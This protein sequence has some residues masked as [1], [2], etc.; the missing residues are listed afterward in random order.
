MKHLRDVVLFLAGVLAFGVL[1]FLLVP[2]GPGSPRPGDGFVL[3]VLVAMLAPAWWKPARGLAAGFFGALTIATLFGDAFFARQWWS[4]VRAAASALARPAMTAYRERREQRSWLARWERVE[5]DHGEAAFRARL[6][7]TACL[8]KW[9][10]VRIDGTV[11]T[12]AELT[13]LDDCGD[14]RRDARDLEVAWP[15][16]FHQESDK[17]WRWSLAAAD[18]PSLRPGPGYVIRLEPEPLLG[19]AGPFLELD[20]RDVMRIRD[21]AAAPSRIYSTP[22]PLMLRLHD[23]FTLGAA[24][25]PDTAIGWRFLPEQR[26][27]RR[28][29]RELYL[30]ESNSVPPD[31]DLEF[32]ASERIANPG[33]QLWTD[34]RWMTYKLVGPRRF[35]LRGSQHFRRYLVS[36]DRTVHVTTENRPATTADPPPLPCEVDVTLSCDD[37]RS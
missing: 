23:C 3:L 29:C 25:L 35:E 32:G 8:P 20:S 10:A 5:L 1:T 24:A 21:S 12:A 36:A 7:A 19:R 26:A 16:R 9:F 22:V 2:W 17:A 11:P 33:T 15:R 14:F 37:G 30:R 28:A 31:A 4:P 27:A 18:L 6:L 13:A 34:P